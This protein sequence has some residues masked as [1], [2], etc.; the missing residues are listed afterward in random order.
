MESIEKHIGKNYGFLFQNSQYPSGSTGRKFIVMS[1]VKSLPREQNTPEV[2]KL[3][4]ECCYRGALFFGEC[5]L[6]NKYIYFFLML[7]AFLYYKFL[8]VC[9]YGI[10]VTLFSF[11]V[12]FRSGFAVFRKFYYVIFFGFDW[13]VYVGNLIFLWHWKFFYI[14]NFFLQNRII[15]F[16]IGNG[17]S[18][19]NNIFFNIFKP[20]LKITFSS[21]EFSYWKIYFNTALL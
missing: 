15:I 1:K 14:K 9:L 16:Q 18:R 7:C 13:K 10:A 20:T 19:N 12:P 3:G 5:I 4:D 6:K 2:V 11:I 8:R 21:W 17:T